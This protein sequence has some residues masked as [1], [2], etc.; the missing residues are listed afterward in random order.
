MAQRTTTTLVDD[1]DASQ[2]AETVP[3]AVDGV[4]YEIDLS[5]TN[6]AHLR[7]ALADYIAHARRTGG[8]RRPTSRSQRPGGSPNGSSAPSATAPAVGAPLDRAQNR[9]IRDWARAQGMT[10]S[11]RGRLSREVVEAFEQAH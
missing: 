8:R 4:T 7:D 5:D 9:A 10:V 11:D 1:L 2:A 6:A 3:F